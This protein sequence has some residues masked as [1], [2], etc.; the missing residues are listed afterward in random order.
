MPTLWIYAH[1]MYN[2]QTGLLLPYLCL[3]ALL[4]VSLLISMAFMLAWHGNTPY[5]WSFASLLPTALTLFV[6]GA[7][8]QTLVLKCRSHISRTSGSGFNFTET[9][10]IIS[11]STNPM[12]ARTTSAASRYYTD[13]LDTRDNTNQSPSVNSG[14]R[15]P[16]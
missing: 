16:K 3:R 7:V 11:S 13:E 8:C 6:L 14:L 4:N 10:R 9:A 12:D 1:A 5:H 15:L 2:G